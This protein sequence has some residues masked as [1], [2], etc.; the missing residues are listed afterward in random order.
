MNILLLFSLFLERRKK[1]KKG[2]DVERLYIQL[3]LVV[4]MVKPPFPIIM[5]SRM[6]LV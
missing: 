6:S 4:A 3:V 2:R 5:A 1:M